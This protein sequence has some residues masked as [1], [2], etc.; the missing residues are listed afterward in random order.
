MSHFCNCKRCRMLRKRK[1]VVL[2][3][4]YT[5]F[6]IPAGRYTTEKQYYFGPVSDYVRHHKFQP[7]R[8]PTIRFD[9][10]DAT[11]DY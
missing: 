2:G 7:S 4:R 11:K 3:T 8:R 1:G 10:R 6:W 5:G 9:A